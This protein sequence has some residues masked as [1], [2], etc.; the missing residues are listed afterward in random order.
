MTDWRMS[1]PVPLRTARAW[2]LTR[3][4]VFAQT[5]Q[6]YP[7]LDLNGL[8]PL[9]GLS[10]AGE[11]EKAMLAE[12]CF[13]EERSRRR[14]RVTAAAA[15]V[16]KR[17]T[18]PL[19]E[20]VMKPGYAGRFSTL[21]RA[22]EAQRTDPRISDYD[23]KSVLDFL[24]NQ[25]ADAERGMLAARLPMEDAKGSMPAALVQRASIDCLSGVR[26]SGRERASG[27]NGRS[28][29]IDGAIST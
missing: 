9:D 20:H 26:R 19:V 8:A 23:R 16:L 3:D 21:A 1:D 28:L 14:Q 5:I 17:K 2:A 29:T 4:P 6:D 7:G 25:L 13:V 24:M 12:G 22:Y 10:I 15:K 27:S 18:A 11:L